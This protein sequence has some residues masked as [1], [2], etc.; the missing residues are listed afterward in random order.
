MKA[1][2]A[3]LVPAVKRWE[4]VNGK[5]LTPDEM[6]ERGVGL[7]MI[8]SGKGPYEERMKDLRNQGDAGCF[9]SHQSLIKHLG[10]LNVPD[11]YGH[12]ILEDDVIIPKNFLKAG[13][14]FSKIQ[15]HVPIDWDILYIGI[16]FPIGKDIGN[17]IMKLEYK[18]GLNST[19]GNGGTDAYIVRH[20]AIRY[21]IGPW[22]EHMID[23]IDQQYKRKFN[24]WN[25][26]AVNPSIII[27][28]PV[29]SLA[30]NSSIQV[31]KK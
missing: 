24:D 10:T 9:L 6:G 27:N 25:V 31:A 3:G 15:E 14:D 12:L 18:P 21:K 11:Y 22:L 5:K 16:N 26:Y 1:S 7:A 20:G 2:T 17:N 4:A 29:L 13:D 8:N 19:L 28:D 30:E 23:L